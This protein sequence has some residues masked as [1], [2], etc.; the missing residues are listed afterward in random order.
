MTGSAA[1]R[2][3]RR[4]LQRDHPGPVVPHPI[5][6]PGLAGPADPG[7]GP[8]HQPGPTLGP[9][10]LAPVR[11]RHPA[12]QRLV[13][14]RRLPGRP[15]PDRGAGSLRPHRRR[16]GRGAVH[17]LLPW[18]VAGSGGAGL[19][20]DR[21]PGG[22]QPAA[23]AHRPPCVAHRALGRL[24]ELAR[25]PSCTAWARAATAGSVGCRAWTWSA[26]WWCWP[27]W[28]GAWAPTGSSTRPAGRSAPWAARW[29]SSWSWAGRPPDP[30]RPVGPARRG[31]P[32]RC[33][34]RPKPLGAA[35]SASG[36][37]SSSNAVHDAAALAIPLHAKLAGH[38]RSGRRRPAQHGSPS[39]PSWWTPAPDR[40]SARCR[41]CS[42]QRS[43]RRG[44]GLAR[45]H[46]DPRTQPASPRPTRG[47]S[48]RSTAI[49]SP[50]RSS[51]RA[52]P[53][54]GPGAPGRSTPPPNR[55]RGRS[56]STAE[57]TPARLAATDPVRL[58][59]RPSATSL[60]EHL[61]RFGP[62][63]PGTRNLIDQVEAAG[64]RGRG[65]AGLPDRHQA[66][67]RGLPVQGPGGGGQRHRGR[68]GQRQ[69][70]GAAPG[71][72]PPGARRDRTGGRAA[73]RGRRLPVHRPQLAHHP[74]RR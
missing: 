14:G 36:S 33:W 62:R 64:L 16:L 7:H 42:G 63:P 43:R 68:T 52:A 58:L 46:H 26:W 28:A 19:R 41:S 5:D 53:L 39:R 70:Q 59:P 48:P 29:C 20:P 65:G 23:P 24:P 74:R 67:G 34:A 47:R 35:T 8:G 10:P 73:G 61:A 4:H 30:P 2:D 9:G 55:S 21:G 50:P 71:R 60:G 38:H 27:R 56:M 72:T 15:H 37:S 17:L 32:G 25:S 13:A 18:A 3:R 11:H 69:G 1:G 51:S 22:H 31:R 49:W 54:R 57:A 45:G 40:R 12:P 6:R 44:S 66:A